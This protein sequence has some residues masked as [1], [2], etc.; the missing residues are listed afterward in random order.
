MSKVIIPK[1]N[2][3][4]ANDQSPI[5]IAPFLRPYLDDYYIAAASEKVSRNKQRLENLL[6]PVEEWIMVVQSLLVW[7]NPR[8]S[9]ILFISANIGL[10]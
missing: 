3:A 9:I 5:Y 7:E 2:M 6:S 4:E 1:Q 8:N 10:W